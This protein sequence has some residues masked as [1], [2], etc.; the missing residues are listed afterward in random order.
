MAR[1]YRTRSATPG[2]AR[3][4]VVQWL[5]GAT[6]HTEYKLDT[7]LFQIG[8]QQISRFQELWFCFENLFLQY[9]CH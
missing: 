4:R 1:N 3:E 7:D 2:A 8:D 9:C 5:D 6:G